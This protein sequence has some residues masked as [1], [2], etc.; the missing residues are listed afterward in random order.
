MMFDY[1]PELLIYDP[2]ATLEQK[3][4]ILRNESV[5]IAMNFAFLTDE[6]Q[7]KVNFH[8]FEHN[9]NPQLFH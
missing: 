9:A 8:D 2:T 4:E 6:Q 3:R 5:Y 1:Y 7:D